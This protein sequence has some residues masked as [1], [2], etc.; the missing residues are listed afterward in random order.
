MAEANYGGA[1]ARGVPRPA[2]TAELL[3]DLHA[4]NLPQRRREQL[5]PAVS[6]DPQAL[7][8]LRSL[9]EVSAQLGALG[10]DER[11]VHPM[12][13]DVAARLTRFVEELHPPVDSTTPYRDGVGS[14]AIAPDNTPP[15]T[16]P[17]ATVRDAAT[18]GVSAP[19][20]AIHRLS[21]VPTH[22]SDSRPTHSES[23]PAEL[24]TLGKRRG[25]KVRWI[26]AAAAAILAVTG[27]G[28]VISALNISAVSN[29]ARPAPNAQISAAPTSGNTDLGEE[30]TATVA[31]GALGRHTATGALASPA[32]LQLCAH[33]NGLDRPVLGSTDITFHGR[34]AVLI[35]LSGPHPPTITALV[36]GTGC[37][38]DDPQQRALQDIG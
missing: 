19:E 29:D 25:G 18:P 13:A 8:F 35:L 38:A 10:R 6:R 27:G 15:V 37:S 23:T 1:M 28:F 26:A 21:F 36:V 2:F 22:E 31:L 24:V 11:I 4:G 3:A 33:A 16:T 20:A 34:N 17:G 7:R 12:P 5:W 30:L 9:D 14:D 32:A